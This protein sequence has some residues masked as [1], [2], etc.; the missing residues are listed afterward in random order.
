[1]RPSRDRPRVHFRRKLSEIVFAENFHL[2][3]ARKCDGCFQSGLH[4]TQA[5]RAVNPPSANV[6]LIFSHGAG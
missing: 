2:T 5:S 6:A 4:S 3:V 1:M